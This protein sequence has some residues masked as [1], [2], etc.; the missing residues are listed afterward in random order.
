M[1]DIVSKIKEH[2]LRITPIR[3]EILTVFNTTDFALSHADI[4]T[5]FAHIYDRV[6][7][8]RTLTAFVE[9]GIIH[10]ISDE[11]GIAKYA[12][13]HHHQIEH[14]H[15]DNHV[16]FK[17]SV[18]EKIE[19]LHSLQIPDF[20]LPKNYTMQQANLLVEGICANC[21]Q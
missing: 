12:M 11:T 2:G 16:H 5:K 9:A 20:H 3:K 4:E 19:C 7:I 1:S 13:C 10:K 8:Y 15:Q 14:E 18:C 17:C 6:T 21:N